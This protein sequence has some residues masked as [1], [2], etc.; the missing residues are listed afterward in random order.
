M[1]TRVGS[2]LKVDSRISGISIKPMENIVNLY[3]EPGV[4]LVLD[5]FTE[6]ISN[7]KFIEILYKKEIILIK[8]SGNNKQ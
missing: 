8:Y 7:N 5:E 1:S 6:P 4:Y 3:I 2:L